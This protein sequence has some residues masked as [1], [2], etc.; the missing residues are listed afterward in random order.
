MDGS[1]IVVSVAQYVDGDNVSNCCCCGSEIGLSSIV[2][3][4]FVGDDDDGVTDDAVMNVGGVLEFTTSTLYP[5][6]LKVSIIASIISR[7]KLPAGI[8]ITI[9]SLVG[10]GRDGERQTKP[11]MRLE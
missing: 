6:R 5:L 2:V 8:M 11:I 3:F 10:I 1:G 9:I 7:C 4:V